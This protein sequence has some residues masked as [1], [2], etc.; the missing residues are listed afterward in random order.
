MHRIAAGAPYGR[1]V[2]TPMP[3]SAV[4]VGVASTISGALAHGPFGRMKMP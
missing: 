2:A 1:W 4:T 3:H